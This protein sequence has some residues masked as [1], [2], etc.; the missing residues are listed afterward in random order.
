VF[1][2]N[3]AWHTSVPSAPFQVCRQFFVGLTFL[4]SKNFLCGPQDKKNVENHCTSITKKK[5]EEFFS[6]LHLRMYF[7][8]IRRF[9]KNSND[10]AKKSS[11]I[12]AD[13]SELFFCYG[14]FC[15]V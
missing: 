5:L 10:V 12:R 2:S 6:L 1:F 7:F 15:C 3:G 8:S 13:F 9:Q 14:S 11:K 4:P